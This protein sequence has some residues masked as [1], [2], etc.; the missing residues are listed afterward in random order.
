[1]KK[2]ILLFVL[3]LLVGCATVTK[4]VA[5]KSNFWENK[6]Q[7]IG[8]AITKSELPT[9]TM[10]GAQG[11]LDLA[12]NRGNAKSLIAYLEKLELPKLSS[13]PTD[14]AT[15]LQARGFNV[16]KIEQPIDNATLSKFSGKSETA[17][18]AELD[19]TKLKLDGIDRLLVVSVERVGT[20]RNYYGF[21][22]TGP[23]QADLALKGQLIDLK[24][25]ELLWYISDVSALPIA[26]PWD[27]PS[28]ENVSTSVKTNVD[29]GIE[30]FEQSFFAGPVQ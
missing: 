5:L 7:A 15:Q 2:I 22:P 21:I 14:F 29:Q 30:K 26:E 19:Y 13:V 4:P 20:T 27:Q 28:F 12:I 9:A 24:T 11:L 8:V 23:P 18:F 25:N 10:T 1:M 17:Q 16:K 6:Q 3:S